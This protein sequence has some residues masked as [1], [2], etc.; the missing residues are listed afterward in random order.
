MSFASSFLLCAYSLWYVLSSTVQAAQ[1]FDTGDVIHAHSISPPI[2]Q[3]FWVDD[4]SS[5]SFGSSTVITDNYIR[6]TDFLLGS[7]GFIRNTQTNSVSTFELNVTLKVRRRNPLSFSSLGHSSVGIWYI[8]A[9]GFSPQGSNFIGIESQFN[10][11]GVV[12]SDADEISL[13]IGN[14]ARAVNATSLN[15]Q[16]AGYCLIPKMSSCHI[17]ITLRFTPGHLGVWYVLHGD[18]ASKRKPHSSTKINIIPCLTVAAPTLKGNHFFGVT[19]MSSRSGL[20]EHDVYEVIM[21][22]IVPSSG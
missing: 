17:T 5:W 2:L 14:G 4:M 8:T 9:E 13:V 3:N 12:L 20:V 22:P 18:A 6:L 7:A 19:A 10:G 11:V 1:E 21:S 15:E 16:R